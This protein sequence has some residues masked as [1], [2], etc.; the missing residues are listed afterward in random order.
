MAMPMA[1]KQNLTLIKNNE[2]KK[3]FTFNKMEEETPLLQGN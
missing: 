2:Q 1:M 3:K